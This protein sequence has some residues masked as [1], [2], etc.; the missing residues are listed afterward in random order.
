MT[1]PVECAWCGGEVDKPFPNRR[2]EDFCSA[3]HRSASGRALRSLQGAETQTPYLAPD[4]AAI[5]D[6]VARDQTIDS[7]ANGNQSDS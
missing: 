7:D 2:G 1:S 5:A 6:I 4:V 3:A